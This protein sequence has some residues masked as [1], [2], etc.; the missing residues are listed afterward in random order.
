VLPRE[1]ADAL[2]EDVAGVGLVEWNRRPQRERV[3]GTFHRPHGIH[4]L[5][6]AN[7]LA[8]DPRRRPQNELEHREPQF[9]T[10]VSSCRYRLAVLRDAPAPST[11]PQTS[12]RDLVHTAVWE[13]RAGSALHALT[14]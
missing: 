6:K 9:F 5:L 8:G 1:S 7:R 3:A 4:A 14:V 2:L 12:I 10:K 13:S 11:P